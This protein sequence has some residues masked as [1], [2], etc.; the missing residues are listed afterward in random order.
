M[1]ELKR[2]WDAFARELQDTNDLYWA[3]E[4]ICLKGPHYEIASV[5]ELREI[6]SW[7]RREA[8]LRAETLEEQSYT[9]RADVAAMFVMEAYLAEP[10]GVEAALLLAVNEPALR[11]LALATLVRRYA[12]EPEVL[13]LLERGTL[14]A[15]HSGALCG[16]LEDVID[17]V[18]CAL[19]GELVNL[20]ILADLVERGDWIEVLYRAIERL[21]P[22]SAGRWRMTQMASGWLTE[23]GTFHRRRQ[24]VSPEKSLEWLRAVPESSFEGLVP[25]RV[26]P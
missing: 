8:T 16:A 23:D 22:S 11:P 2:L 1:D 25:P 7:S 26:V 6:D 5:A 19:Y 9:G 20:I 14:S 12:P 24:K 10:D 4:K 21:Y 13:G 18:S 17:G 15:A 3:F